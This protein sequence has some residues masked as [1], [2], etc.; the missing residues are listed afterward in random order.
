MMPHLRTHRWL[1]DADSQFIA[2]ASV[3]QQHGELPERTANLVARRKIAFGHWEAGSRHNACVVLLRDLDP[4]TNREI[5]DYVNAEWRVRGLPGQPDLIVFPAESTVFHLAKA[6][7]T[8]FDAKVKIPTVM[9]A[10]A[11]HIGLDVEMR[12]EPSDEVH[13]V[14]STDKIRVLFVDDSATSGRTELLCMNAL[15]SERA[16]LLKARGK[17]ERGLT[18]CSYV[19]AERSV[20]GDGG[21]PM[22]TI[23]AARVQKYVR[24]FFTRFAIASVPE[25]QCP[26]CVAAARMQR[27][28]KWAAGSRQ[29]IRSLIYAASGLLRVRSIEASTIGEPIILPEDERELLRLLSMPFECAALDLIDSP[30]PE[31][32][33]V[34]RMLFFALRYMDLRSYIR[35]EIGAALIVAA[36]EA[37]VSDRIRQ[38]SF[39]LALAIL[40]ASVQGEILKDLLAIATGLGAINFA[41]AMSA[42]VF[43]AHY[44]ALEPLSS[45]DSLRVGGD[46]R[47]RQQEKLFIECMTA[48][49]ETSVAAEFGDAAG[50]ISS[51]MRLLYAPPRMQDTLWLARRLSHL[52]SR[53]RHASFLARQIE[54]PA[55]TD[56]SVIRDSVY[57]AL[58]LFRAL[59]GQLGIEDTA[60]V[61]LLDRLQQ[62]EKHDKNGIRAIGFDL[63]DREWENGIVAQ[64]FHSP[65]QIANILRRCRNRIYASRAESPL[66]INAIRLIDADESISGWFGFGPKPGILESHFDNLFENAFKFY[67]RSTNATQKLSRIR[68]NPN[69]DKSASVPIVEMG[70][71]ACETRERL[72]VYCADRG[73]H[74]AEAELF[75]SVRGLTNARAH[76]QNFSGDI[77][78]Y[79]DSSIGGVKGPPQMEGL[80]KAD[81]AN[82]F[83]TTLPLTQKSRL[84]TTT[85]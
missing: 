81:Y 57:H 46:L 29:A 69:L 76:L 60:I 9:A 73:R 11:F 47:D 27:S 80:V 7:Q 70:F 42:T 5:A 8:A 31:R 44:D 25:G 1:V 4:D 30:F 82:F 59:C 20:S 13:A 10:P 68:Y 56:A 49:D 78:Y 33:D 26:L 14:L 67:A 79:S 32:S 38:V 24:M 40:P 55:Q 37:A 22:E 43:A 64:F 17:R 16:K 21:H 77:E 28:Y 85:L 51:D 75:A 15:L 52:L 6:L 62:I 61:R 54:D 19:I 41:G 18:W 65:H 50:V 3:S 72:F 45:T 74:A 53:G 66:P 84:T 39:I 36:C 23:L 34:G 48:I 71:F 35:S 58:T 2:R 12:L 63:I 83:I